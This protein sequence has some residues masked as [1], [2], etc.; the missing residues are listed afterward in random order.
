MSRIP[1][2]KRKLRKI[3][4]IRTDAGSEFRSDTFRKWCSKNN[5]RFTTAAP[6]HREQNGL[7]ERHWGTIM[8][9]ANTML[10]HARLSKKFLYY[11]VKY[12][13]YIHDVIPVEDLTDKLGL[14]CTPY[15]MVNGIKPNVRH[16]RVFGCPSIFKRYEISEGGKRTKNKYI[17]QRDRKSVV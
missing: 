6:K 2:H 9:L 13:Q 10:I 8:K 15:Q 4:H 17:Q 3:S 11:T 12:A 7:V 16:F 1:N 5:I 14:P